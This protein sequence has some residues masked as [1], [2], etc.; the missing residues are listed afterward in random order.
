MS[1]SL[2][3]HTRGIVQQDNANYEVCAGD[4]DSS[5]SSGQSTLSRSSRGYS[6]RTVSRE[7]SQGSC[8]Q[9]DYEEEADTTA[10]RTFA[11]SPSKKPGLGTMT[12]KAL[13]QNKRG[14]WCKN[15]KNTD[16][17]K[18]K[19]P[20]FPP[21]KLLE[22]PNQRIRSAHRHRIK[23]LNSQ[24]WELQQQLSGVSTENKL[25]KQLQGRHMLALQHFQDSQSGLPQVLAKHGSEVRGLQELLRKARIR[26]NSLSRHLR[27]T[28][29]ELLRTKDAL[30]RLQLLS[31]DRSLEEREELSHRLALITVDLNRKNKRIQDLERNLELRQIS[32]N[33]HLATETRKT[34]EARELSDYLQAQISLST[35]KIKEKERELEIHNIYSHRFP[36][37]WNGKGARETKSV[38]TDDLSS[39][40][41]E[42]PC[43]LELEYA[44]SLEHLELE[45]QKSL[46]WE[47]FAIDFTDRSDAADTSVDDRGSKDNEDYAEDG[48][49]D[50]GSEEDPQL[51]GEENCL[52]EKA[53]SSPKASG[54]QT[55]PF[56]SQVR[57]TP[58]D[59]LNTE[60]ANKALESSPRT[61]RLYKFKETIQNLHSGKPAY[62]SHTHSL[63]K[64]P[65]RYIKSQ[66]RV[67]NLGSG[68]YEP[69]FVTIPADTTGPQ[70]EEG[71]VRSK[72]SSLM[73]ELFGQ[74]PITDPMAMQKGRSRVQSTDLDR[75]SSYHTGDTSPVSPGRE[76]K[77][78]FD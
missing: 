60:R 57:Y 22:G 64:S 68:A 39:L 10:N 34:N 53:A 9:S 45:K 46:S 11:L 75:M 54:E 27:G 51:Q 55:E 26:R 18:R 40:P 61:K 3:H 52:A 66:A 78:I 31:E 41:I 8:T 5:C 14:Q 7:D 12:A 15:K 49:L 13:T 2:R 72:K 1:L 20:L 36:K 35:K 58:E 33:R 4:A 44:S 48:E 74:A 30:H 50:G 25:L 17:R 70:P 59:F 73:K 65:P 67:E 37:G 29:E 23:E 77:I 32:F 71:V 47:S 76:T 63:R 43:Q 62:T 28:E 21:I 24:V 6:S 19:A 38:Q 69:S 16:S 56:E 42:A